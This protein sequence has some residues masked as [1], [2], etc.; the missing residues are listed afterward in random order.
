MQNIIS[1]NNLSLVDRH[2]KDI[3]EF[4]FVFEK[5]RQY[6]KEIGIDDKDFM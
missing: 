3:R 6:E 1:P 4:P 2:A 5:I